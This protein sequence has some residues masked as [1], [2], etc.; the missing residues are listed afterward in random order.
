MLTDGGTVMDLKTENKEALK[1]AANASGAS[2]T[3][4]DNLKKLF[5]IT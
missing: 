5:G 4:K 1:A 3:T 2:E